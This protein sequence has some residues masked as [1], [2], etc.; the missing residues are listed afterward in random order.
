MLNSSESAFFDS[1]VV[2]RDTSSRRACG[3]WS[4]V[5]S[6]PRYGS[7][8]LRKLLTEGLGCAALTFRFSPVFGRGG[9]AMFSVFDFFLRLKKDD[10]FLFNAGGG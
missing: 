6:W 2:G 9:G 4:G 10:G 7:M 5:P 8:T 1:W 3:E